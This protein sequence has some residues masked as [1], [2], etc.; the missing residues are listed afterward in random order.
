MGNIEKE[1]N[2]DKRV[3][4]FWMPQ[5]KEVEDPEGR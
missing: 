4:S 5:Y 1:M 2:E 3:G